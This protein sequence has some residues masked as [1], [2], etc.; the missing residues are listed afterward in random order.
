MKN[1]FSTSALAVGI[2][3]AL[4]LNAGTVFAEGPTVYGKVNVS[5]ESIDNEGAAQVVQNKAAAEVD[6]WEWNSNAS[7]LGVKGS[8]DLE[9]SGL[10]A[11]Y[12]AEYEINVDDGDKGDT[13]FSQRNIFGGIQG[14]FG[15]VI[16]GKFDSPLKSAE[17]KVDQFNDLKGDLDYLIGGQNRNANIGQ[18]SSPKLADSIVINAAFIA[19]EGSDTDQDGEPDDSVSDT[20]SVSVVFDNKQYYAALAFET[21]QT[22]R[23]SVDGISRGDLIRLVGGAKF[24]ALELG[25]L[26]QQTQDNAADSDAQDDS[27]LVSAAYRINKVKLKAQY[28]I[29]E[30][31]V[32]DESG[33]LTALGA[34][35]ALSDKSVIYAY[36]SQLDLDE[37]DLSDKTLG[38]GVAH[39]F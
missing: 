8:F 35:Y 36:A 28:G 5:L 25:A 26:L 31:D 13:A 4:G 3:T 29:S 7:R 20:V 11:L 27:Y 16:Y 33:S 23:R 38:I 34:D 22:A 21:D 15:T 30:G 6:Q 19:A 12:Q 1:R 9:N 39:T 2:A 24:G 37:A 18:Y 17:G 10:K 32:S 14:N